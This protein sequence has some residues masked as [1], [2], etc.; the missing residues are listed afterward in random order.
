MSETDRPQDFS[1]VCVTAEE[2]ANRSA[3]ATVVVISAA[4]FLASLD[5]FI[6]NVAFP[7]IRR[8]FHSA[9]LASMSWILNAYTIV[10]V[11]V[12]APAGRLGDRYGH[13]RIFLA[14]LAVFLAG[15]LA[16]GLSTTF[17]MLVASR[18]LQALGAGMLM[19]S[20]LALLLAAV[21]ADRR[22]REVG[23]WSAV[24]AMAAAL[25]PPLGGVLVGFSWQWIFIV[26]L[27]IGVLVVVLG[28]LILRETTPSGTDVPD[29][30]GA[31]ALVVGVAALVWALIEVPEFHIAQSSHWPRRSASPRSP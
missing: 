7:D 1:E 11:A 10:F 31:L 30:I 22:S 17:A 23:M 28:R 25:G 3:A 16:C 21:P 4:A 20:S 9:D 8:A 14:G 15:S 12:L 26:N 18:V 6:V 13:R 2:S 5:L 29:L 27:P 19:P 24:G